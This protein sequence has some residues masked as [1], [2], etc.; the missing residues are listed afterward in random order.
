MIIATDNGYTLTTRGMTMTL[1]RSTFASLGA[2]QMETD[3]ASARAWNRMP[4][5]KYF[6]SLE[7]VE[8]AYKSWRGISELIDG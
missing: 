7:A 5:V 1:S 4:S 2:W 8:A 3:N 6:D